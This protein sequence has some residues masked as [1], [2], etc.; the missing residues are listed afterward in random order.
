[1][2]AEKKSLRR[3]LV[4]YIFSTTFLFVI[5]GY[6]Y[7]KLSY[8]NIIDNS[9]LQMR[10]NIH[11]FIELNHEKRFLITG[12]KPNYDG[13]KINIYINSTYVLGNFHPSK[14]SLDQA[15]WIKGKY[16]YYNY[17]TQKKWGMMNFIT[18]K[19]IENQIANLQ[20]KLFIFSFFT[21]IFVVFMAFIL[22]KIFLSPMKKSLTFLE[23]FISDTTHEINTPLSNILTNIEMLNE[24]YPDF[25]NNEE[26]KKINTSVFR[27]SKIFKDLTF[28]K[29]NHNL[30]K[31]IKS[32]KIDTIL[33]DRIIFFENII[34]NKNIELKT[35]ISPLTIK[36]DKE[37][38]IRLFDNILSNA[39]KYTPQNGKIFIKLSSKCFE[40]VNDGTIQKP[41]Q[42][43]EKFTRESKSEGG[44]G[45]GLYIV[46][47]IVD[48]YHFSYN[49]YS[50][51][52]K[53]F[54]K[55]CFK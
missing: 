23:E 54:F 37:D 51:D 26:L 1:M 15:Y 47:K 12:E 20:K 49:L 45:L 43:F 16:L 29:L 13:L 46:K 14:H 25:K 42:M 48:Y 6:F 33:K 19:N 34:Q 7:Y 8:K 44:F 28:A 10:N 50:K 38:M 27:I 36:V 11:H 55:V 17:T 3:F 22:G 24:L 39:I 2:L 41:K 31:N 32:Q 18:Y 40:T 9:I 30:T 4:I 35:D 53:V 21:L 52:K 5:G